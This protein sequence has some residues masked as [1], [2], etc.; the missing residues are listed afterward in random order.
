MEYLLH[1]QV[2]C[3]GTIHSDM[4]YLPKRTWKLRR[5]C[6]RGNVMIIFPMENY[7]FTSGKTTKLWHCYPIFMERN[8]QRSYKH[9]KMEEELISI[10]PL[11]QKIIAPIW[12]VLT[13][14]ICWYHHMGYLE[15]QENCG[16]EF[17]LVCLI[18]HYVM[19]LLLS[20]RLLKQKWKVLIFE[21]G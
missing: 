9:K 11:Q 7:C 18:E 17:F 6:K 4:K 8:Q 14:Q 15:N 3:C 20:I 1:D 5:H 13:R 21:E 19:H 12:V 10:S 16:T 2:Y